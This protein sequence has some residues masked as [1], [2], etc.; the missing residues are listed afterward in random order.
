ME[1]T[2]WREFGSVEDNYPERQLEFPVKDFSLIYF[3]DSEHFLSI[4][5][6]RE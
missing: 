2:L 4:I 1:K 6:S 3:Y 5:E